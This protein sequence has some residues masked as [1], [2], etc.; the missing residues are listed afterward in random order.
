MKKKIFFWVFNS[1]FFIVSVVSADEGQ[2]VVEGIAGFLPIIILFLVFYFAIVRPVNKRKGGSRLSEL[3]IFIP[4]I[5]LIYL[6]R[7]VS[8]TDKAVLEKIDS[9]EKKLQKLC[10]KSLEM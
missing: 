9:L 4:L 8:L 6:W 2:S 10:S 5:N 1:V 7:L 3:L